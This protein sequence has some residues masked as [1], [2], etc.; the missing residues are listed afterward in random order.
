[1]RTPYGQLAHR[2]DD[3]AA[4]RPERHWL[5]SEVLDGGSAIGDGHLGAGHDVAGFAAG[6]AVV[7]GRQVAEN[8]GAG[9]ISERVSWRMVPAAARRMTSSVSLSPARTAHRTARHHERMVNWISGAG[10]GDRALQDPG[11]GH[12][13]AREQAECESRRHDDEHPSL[14]HALRLPSE[15]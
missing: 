14:H 6:D 1:V 5:E 8:I 12:R 13:V 4:D 2:I 3:R 10:V 7:A 11:L 15:H 9:C